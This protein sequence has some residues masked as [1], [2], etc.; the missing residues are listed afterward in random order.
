MRLFYIFKVNHKYN[1]E[2][3]FNILNKIYLNELRNS[4]KYYKELIVPINSKINNNIYKYY[5]NDN[6][7]SKFKNIHLY[8]NYYTLEKSKLIIKNSYM[9]LDT[10]SIKSIFFKYL[11]RSSNIFICDFNNL[12]YFYLDSIA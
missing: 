11:K 5:H 1:K 3:L 2:E 10:N 8:N 7:Y 12:D 6:N 4:Y 9:L